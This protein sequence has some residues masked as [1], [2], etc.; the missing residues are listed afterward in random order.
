V[1][2]LYLSNE[3]ARYN[4]RYNEHFHWAIFTCA[5]YIYLMKMLVIMA[6][7]TIIFIGQ[8]LRAHVKA[9][10]WPRYSSG[11]LNISPCHPYVAMLFSNIKYDS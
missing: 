11:I 8:F 5:R 10:A 4:G 2:T 3:N 1:R 6:A 7:K 9:T